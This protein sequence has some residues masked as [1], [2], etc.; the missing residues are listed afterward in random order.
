LPTKAEHVLLDTSAALALVAPENPFHRGA[1]SRLRPCRRGMSGHA[2]VE[3]LS[4][5]TRLPAPQRLTPAM[6]LRLEVTNFPDSRF[7]SA[8]GTADLLQEFAD[9]GLAGGAVYDG[10]VGAAAREHQ[11]LLITCDRRAES[12][13]R[14][15]GVTYELLVK[16]PAS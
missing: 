3:L 8:S 11:L 6:A 7:L 1:I 10:L 4:V 5:L 13:Y 9:A 2:A 16:R 15:L 14:A 12:T